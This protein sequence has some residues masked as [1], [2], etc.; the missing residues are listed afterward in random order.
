M[1]TAQHYRAI[2]RIIANSG[3]TESGFPAMI[4]ALAEMFQ[5][6]NIK[7]DRERFVNACNIMTGESN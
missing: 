2:A 1:F 3:H 4:E 7:F 5:Q 6:D